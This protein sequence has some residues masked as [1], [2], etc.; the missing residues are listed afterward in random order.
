MYICKVGTST[1]SNWSLIRMCFRRIIQ[2]WWCHHLRCIFITKFG[3]SCL[4]LQSPKT[5]TFAEYRANMQLFTIYVYMQQQTC[6][7][8]TKSS[9]NCARF[10]ILM[11]YLVWNLCKKFIIS[12]CIANSL[13]W[14]CVTQNLNK[15]K[16]VMNSKPVCWYFIS[17]FHDTG[18]ILGTWP[19]IMTHSKYTSS[20]FPAPFTL[21]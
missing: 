4:C 2:G 15:Q 14:Q 21:C 18:S 9:I 6:Q 12:F 10:C 7:H 17:I 13:L 19:Y 11:N 1:G 20:N 8:Y 3:Q 5:V 16:T